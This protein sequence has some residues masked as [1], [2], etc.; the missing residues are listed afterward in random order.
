MKQVFIALC[1]IALFA[2]T[3]QAEMRITEWMYNG[4]NGEF[5]EFTNIGSEAIDMKNWS[6]D[7][8]SRTANTIDLSAFG[9]VAA[10][11]SVILTDAASAADFRTA[12]GL[13]TTVKVIAG[14][15]ANLGRN[16]ELNLFDESDVLADRLTFGDQNIP[17]TI[18]TQNVGG[19]P[20]S[21]GV[22]GENNVAGWV[23]S[24]V[25]DGFGSYA[26][27]GG[28]IGNPGHFAVPEPGTLAMLAAGSL[29]LLAFAW[30]KRN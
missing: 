8:D 26:S 9:T 5:I 14:N 18:R 6:F 13:A 12:W 20:T 10:G 19:N 30:R 15:S 17:G 25:G 28:D 22:L 23:L 21:A 16:D 27:T 2:A 24:S 7:D 4:T 11:E 1:V 3:A 29:G